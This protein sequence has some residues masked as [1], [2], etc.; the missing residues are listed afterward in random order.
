MVSTGV[1]P[2][3][4]TTQTPM[5]SH[6]L[7]SLTFRNDTH[8][9]GRQISLNRCTFI[10]N[11]RARL[12]SVARGQQPSPSTAP[13]ADTSAGGGGRGG[14]GGGDGE[15]DALTLPLTLSLCG[16]SVTT[17]VA[18]A[19]AVELDRDSN[20]G[21]G[22]LRNNPDVLGSKAGGG[23]GTQ[24]PPMLPSAASLSVPERRWRC[25]CRDEGHRA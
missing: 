2:L 8:D 22:N 4:G 13:A 3:Q 21:S 9:P 1:P 24:P 17:L 23:R 16:T 6:D 14:G 7:F 5:D 11:R 15:R 12:T 25:R 10:Q 20:G 19:A 18:P